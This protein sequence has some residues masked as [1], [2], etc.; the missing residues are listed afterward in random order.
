MIELL[1]KKNEIESCSQDEITEKTEELIDKFQRHMSDDKDK[2]V[3]FLPYIHQHETFE[4][5]MNDEEI[6]L[7]AGT[8]AGK[9]LAHAIPLFYKVK[10]GLVD[11]ILLLYPTRALLQDQLNEMSELANIYELEDEI[12]EIKGGMSRTQVIAALNK[13]II[14]ATPDSIYWFFNKNIKY[15][16]FLIYGLAQVDEVVID[17]AHLFTGLVLNNLIFLIERMK[18]LARMIDQEQRYHILTATANESLKNIHK[19]KVDEIPGKSNCGNINLRVINKEDKFSGELFKESL[20]EDVIEV[21]GKLSSVA[22][23]NSAKVAHQLFY[24]N[25]QEID[26]EDLSEEDIDRFTLNGVEMSID[27][28]L[29]NIEEDEK[30]NEIEELLKKEDNLKLLLDKILLREYL[31]Q[32]GSLKLDFD[33]ENVFAIISNYLEEGYN[34][35]K[36]VIEQSDRQT[37]DFIDNLE[38]KIARDK[39]VSEIYNGLKIKQ[40]LSIYDDKKLVLDKVR[41]GINKIKDIFQDQIEAKEKIVIEKEKYFNIKFI[42]Y[43]DDKYLNYSPKLANKLAKELSLKDIKEDINFKDVKDIELD[44][45]IFKEILED[46][47]ND[48]WTKELKVLRY[49]A[50][51]KED[52]DTLVVL[53][54]GS[55]SNYVR[56]GLMEFFNE[57][58]YKKKIL[59]STSAVEVG[60]DFDCD[61]LITEETNVASFLQRFGRAGRSGKDSRVKLFISDNSYK[62]IVNKLVDGKELSRNQFSEIIG[63]VFEEIKGIEDK[64]FLEAYHYIINQNLGRI[65]D[66][67]NEEFNENVKKLGKK[68]R[69]EIDLNY[70]L[71]GTMPSVSLKGGVSKNPFYILRFLENGDLFDL[72]SPFEIASTDKSF[73]SLIWMS[74]G[75]SEDVYVD[76]N[77][78]LKHSKLMFVEN[79]GELKPY[80]REGICDRYEDQ[81]LRRSKVF[82]QKNEELFKSDYYVKLEEYD[83][84]M[85]KYLLTDNYRFVLGFGDIFLQKDSGAVMVEDRRLNIPNQFFL[86]LVG[87]EEEQKDY[88]NWLRKNK[89]FDYG[90]IIVDDTNYENKLNE[91]HQARN[92]RGLILLENINGALFYLYKRLIKAQ[93]EGELL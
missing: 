78:T 5:I 61:L 6:L 9:T 51:W 16:S 55:M 4:R 18:K 50:N 13:K 17:E 41:D 34:R 92:P 28:L 49:I 93:K 33:N 91:E 15:S 31:E 48:S 3:D 25:T 23:L 80:V 72:D 52:K 22:I 27:K 87:D 68:L 66:G 69:E 64:D 8:S 37:G 84:G 74:Y 54:T 40:D 65:G 85:L 89:I 71:R 62:N 75:D 86:F 83:K 32:N 58:D 21:D 24:S 7:T 2:K 53:Y 45:E 39:Y 1:V 67:L 29:E 35:F 57:A 77:A 76:I 30:Q 11:K 44:V 26:T 90:E 82:K 19:G 63:E 12:A 60:V 81:F 20:R 47:F 10:E 43:G 73:D 70:G 88:M 14:I 38:E 59:L 79:Q 46:K 56:E 36:K 42:K